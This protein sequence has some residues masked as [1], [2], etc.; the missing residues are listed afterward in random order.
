[1]SRLRNSKISNHI[2]QS[3]KRNQMN[4]RSSQARMYQQ[5]YGQEFEIQPRMDEQEAV[6]NSYGIVSRPR[7]NQKALL[8]KYGSRE[9]LNIYSRNKGRKKRYK[10][11]C[12]LYT[13]PS[14]RDLSTSRMPSSA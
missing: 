1:M 8:E 14:P 5:E 7:V 11:A 12:L 9:N 3:S 4:K 6:Y 13:S 10:H 2:E